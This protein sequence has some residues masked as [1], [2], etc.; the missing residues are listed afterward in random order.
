MSSV[1][2]PTGA[3]KWRKK[4][5]SSKIESGISQTLQTILLQTMTE[6][7]ARRRTTRLD[8]VLDRRATVMRDMIGPHVDRALNQLRG[9]G[10]VVELCGSYARGEFR[11]HSD[12]D[13]LI[14]DKGKLT[15]TDIFIIVS[16][17]LRDVSFDIV[18][19]EHLPPETA[20][21]FLLDTAHQ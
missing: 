14:I 2:S 16:D 21:L 15:E 12:V 5:D 4:N 13:F 3:D 7:I 9:S 11:S 8:R 18:Y 20:K 19:L 6:S 1:A 10:V 17:H